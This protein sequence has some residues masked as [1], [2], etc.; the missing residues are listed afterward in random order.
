[1]T[2]SPRRVAERIGMRFEREAIGRHGERV[3]IYR[4]RRSVP[5]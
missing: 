5:R 3:A 2:R 4:L 1:M